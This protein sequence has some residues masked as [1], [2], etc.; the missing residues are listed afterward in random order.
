MIPCLIVVSLDTPYSLGVVDLA[1]ERSME[2]L[3]VMMDRDISALFLM[4]PFSRVCPHL[5]PHLV[6]WQP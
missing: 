5:M 6:C 2:V 4:S 3:E 1:L